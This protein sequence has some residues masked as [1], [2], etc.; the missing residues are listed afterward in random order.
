MIGTTWRTASSTALMGDRTMRLIVSCALV[1]SWPLFAFGQANE[2]ERRFGVRLNLEFYPQNTPR[3]TLAALMRALE[4]DRYDYIV[5]FLLDPAFVEAQLQLTYPEFER[6]ASEQLRQ[7]V[8][9]KKIVN[10]AVVRQR[11]AELAKHANF[12]H[13]VNR[14]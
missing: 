14:V 3:N 7:E 8:L 10:P 9:E 1:L 5:A 11:T 2:P 6:R 4:K 13:L 12:D